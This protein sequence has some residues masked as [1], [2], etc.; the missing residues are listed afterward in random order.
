MVSFVEG[1][2][3]TPMFMVE[4]TINTHRH[5]GGLLKTTPMLY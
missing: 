4:K 3:G 1:L 5:L 2:E